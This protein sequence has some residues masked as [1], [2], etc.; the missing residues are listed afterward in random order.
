MK[1]NPPAAFPVPWKRRINPFSPDE[2]EGIGTTTFLLTKEKSQKKVEGEN[3][4]TKE[5]KRGN[6][7]SPSISNKNKSILMEKKEEEKKRETYSNSSEEKG[8][9][10]SAP[11]EKNDLQNQ[12][13]RKIKEKGLIYFELGEG[14]KQSATN[15]LH[16]EE[17]SKAEVK[18]KGRECLSPHR[19]KK[20]RGGATVA[21]K[22]RKK[23]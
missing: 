23:K 6:R 4:P 20:E 2:G 13:G 15:S 17:N 11:P 10:S 18:K 21:I 9:V 1:Q 3:S 19:E 14:K 22:E 16:S 5:R 12:L 7:P 8:E